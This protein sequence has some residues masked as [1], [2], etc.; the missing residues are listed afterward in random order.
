MRAPLAP[1]TA[2]RARPVLEDAP[3][4]RG[5]MGPHWG[6]QQRTSSVSM[7]M[8]SREAEGVAPSDLD[9]R[10][11]RRPT[12]KTAIRFLLGGAAVVALCAG[13]VKPGDKAGAPAN[14]HPAI[15]L[16][17]VAGPSVVETRDSSQ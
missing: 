1:G 3:D 17:A 15:P 10:A 2:R 11:P 16:E 5:V 8:A 13:M 6:P 7:T 14:T 4:P 9:G 12:I